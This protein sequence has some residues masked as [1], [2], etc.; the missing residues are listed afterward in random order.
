M[1]Q[2]ECKMSDLEPKLNE[3]LPKLKDR[4]VQFEQ[5]KDA[6]IE[7]INEFKKNENKSLDIIK[8]SNT[9]SF[10][11]I[12]YDN[13]NMLFIIIII[14]LVLNTDV[15]K[16]IIFKNIPQLMLNETQYNLMG[17]ILSALILGICTIL[18][19]FYF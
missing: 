1:S 13:R 10:S 5:I 4:R 18:I 12:L 2:F 16:E 15:L 17:L 3:Q 11:D 19:N 14:Y 9:L 7:D 6:E 8:N